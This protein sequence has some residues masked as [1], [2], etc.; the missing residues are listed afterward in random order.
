[1]KVTNEFAIKKAFDMM[2]S[3]LDSMIKESA[4]LSSLEY[5][6]SGELKMMKTFMQQYKELKE[7]SIAL[8]VRYDEQ[9]DKIDKIL[10]TV[11]NIDKKVK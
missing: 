11:E 7:L 6:D 4:S 2:D 9:N 10:E 8:A 5:M 3:T 1:M